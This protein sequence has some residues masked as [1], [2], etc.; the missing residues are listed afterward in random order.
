MKTSSITISIL[1]Q[2]DNTIKKALSKELKQ[3]GHYLTGSLERSIQG[4]IT[5]LNNGA[6]LEGTMN[7]YGYIIDAG[8]TPDRIP[9]QEKSGAKNSKYISALTEYFKLR[10]GL[11]EKEAARAAFATAKVQKKEGMPTRDSY[12]YSKNNERK[13]FIERTAGVIS[14][15]LDTIA[16]TK[17]DDAFEKI[18]NQQQSEII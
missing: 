18:F 13:V 16:S 9:Y 5:T 14:S 8:V 10:K 6:A 3:Q 1:K 2:A 17:M 11:S 12:T 4:N 15:I 7:N